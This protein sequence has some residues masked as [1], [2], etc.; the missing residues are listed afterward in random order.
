MCFKYLLLGHLLGDFTFQTDDI[1]G[2]KTK[3]WEWNL[4]HSIIVTLS[5]LIFAIYFGPRIACLVILNGMLHFVIDYYK[6]RL[7]GTSP[8]NALTFFLADQAVHLLIIFYISSFY[9]GDILTL[10][11]KGELLDLLIIIALISSCASIF[12][13]YILRLFFVVDRNNFFF[14]NEKI[15]GIITRILIFLIL[16][17]SIYF[18]NMILLII[19][20]VLIA[21][22]VYYRRKWHSLMISAYFYSGLLMDLLI[23]SSIFYF[24]F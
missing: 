16:Y 14:E 1:A 10:P 2:N 15:A 19:I 22:T 23:P 4:C 6:S 24:V 8:L 11:M 18:T 17:S 9:N 13:Q 21:K 3:Q 20:A 7:P 12:I 5:M